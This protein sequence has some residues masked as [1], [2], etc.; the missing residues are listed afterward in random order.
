M[1]DSI[2]G[3]LTSTP[4]EMLVGTGNR[5]EGTIKSVQNTTGEKQKSELKKAA[6]EFESVFMAYMLKAM[7]ETIDDSGLTEGGFGKSIYTEMFDQELSLSMAQRGVLGIS[8]LIYKN[9]SEKEAQKDLKEAG[10]T[11]DSIHNAPASE[12]TSNNEGEQEISDLQLPVQAPV[13]SQ[14]GLR[15]DPFSHR[16]RMHNGVDL[17]VPEGTKV[18]A[19]LAGTVVSARYE[20]GYGNSILIQHSGGLQT[21]YAHLSLMN[22]KA[23]DMVASQQVIGNVGDT[24]RSTGSHLH[25]EVIRMGKAIDPL[26]AKEPNTASLAYTVASSKRLD[27]DKQ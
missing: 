23:G 26:H 15:R 18:S 4:T 5:L 22:V 12:I 27:A 20:N 24:G 6:Q 11:P 7:R 9:L 21:R 2:N 13:S 19:P 16:D 8:N 1:Q 14:F 10:K 17:A 25:F 3:S